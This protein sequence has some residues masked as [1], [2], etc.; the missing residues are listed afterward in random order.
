MLIG[1]GEVRKIALIALLAVGWLL[2]GAGQVEAL[3]DVEVDRVYTLSEQGVMSVSETETITNTFDNQFIPAGSERKHYFVISAQEPEQREQVAEAIYDTLRVSI[4]SN[5]VSFTRFQE[6]N[7][8]GASYKT[9][10]QLNPKE[11]QRVQIR[12]VH[13]ELGE[14]VGGLLDAYIPAFSED[15]EFEQGNTKYTYRT[16]LRIPSSAGTEN[17]VSVEP[18]S[19]FSEGNFDVYVFDQNKLL[20]KFVWVQRG[21]SQ[22]YKFSLVQPLLP[23]AERA[24]GDINRYK[25]IIPRDMVEE[26]IEQRI[27]LTEISP[28][29]IGINV[30]ADGNLIGVFQVDAN[31]ET[32]VRIEGYAL[33]QNRGA[34]RRLSEVAG[35]LEALDEVDGSSADVYLSESEFWEVGNS[36]IQEAALEKGGETTDVYELASNIYEQV[37]AEI[38]YSEVKRFGINES[39]GALRTLEGGAAVCMEYSDLYLSLLRARGVPTRAAF[40]YGYDSR[41]AGNAQE[42]HQWVQ[43]YLPGT[44][45]WITVDVTWGETGANVIGGD[46]N[47]FFTHVASSDPNTPSVLSRLSL[48][49]GGELLSPE[50]EVEVVESIPENVEQEALTQEELLEKYPEVEA[51]SQDYYL[52]TLRSKYLASWENL[53]GGRTNEIDTQGWLLMVSSILLGVVALLVFVNLAILLRRVLVK[54]KNQIT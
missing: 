47:H 6:G 32:D 41:L 10:S 54:K 48:S 17:I 20:G 45:S 44:N 43:V 4:Q 7:L 14:R 40:G 36:A 33:L 19:N 8:Y 31:E 38:D 24:S 50:F 1:A 46:L 37:V 13:P 51:N 9:T 11:I 35:S 42:P 22:V 34:E 39:Q 49:G 2:F 26:R 21:D 5:P 30:D 52:E 53:A 16:R 18:N 27:Y 29:P 25:I 12:Y 23:T 3:V 28:E 15:F